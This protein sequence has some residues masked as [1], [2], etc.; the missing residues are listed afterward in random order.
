ARDKIFDIAGRV[1]IALLKLILFRIEV[2]FA[3]G[4][5]GVFAELEPAVNPIDARQR[6]SQDRAN[7]KSRTTATWQNRRQNVGG[8]GPKIASEILA[9]LRLSKFGEVIDQFLFV[10]TPGEIGITLVKAGLGQHLHYLWSSKG[11]R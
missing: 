6:G 8:V 1:P 11:F 2:F 4:Q 3:P 10:I 7:H 5:S 9:H